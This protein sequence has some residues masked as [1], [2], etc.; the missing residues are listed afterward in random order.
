MNYSK[1]VAAIDDRI[2]ANGRREITGQTLHD[3]LEAMV[4]SLGAG[5]QV[6]GVLSPDDDPG[7]PD[8][9][10][11]FLAA[12]PGVYRNCGGLAVTELSW[13]IWG[14]GEWILKP[15]DVPFGVTVQEWIR[16]AVAEERSRALIAEALLQKNIDTEAATREAE[17][18]ALGGR[19]DKE[20]SD[21]EAAVA[22]EADARDKADKALQA[23][24]DAEATERKDA[25]AAEA[26]ARTDADAALGVRIDTETAER[27]QADADEKAAREAADATLQGNIDKEQERAEGAESALRSG[28][29]QEVSDRKEAVAAEASARDAAD[30][31]LGGRIDTETSERKAADA[32]EADTRDKAD[33]ALQAAIDAEEAART[34]ADTKEAEDRAAAVK[35]EADARTAADTALGT[36]IDTETTDRKA[37]DTALGGRIDTEI[38]DRKTADTA[39]D[40][41][42]TAIEG[43][44]PATASA[45]NKLADTEFVNSSIATA[46]ATFRGTFDTLETLKATEA[47][48]N[49]YAFYVHKDEAGNTCYDKYTYDGA[50]WKFEYRLNNSSFTAA[51]WAALNSGITA[52]VIAALQ[53]ADKTNAAAIAKEVQDR[54]AA[55]AAEETARQDAD[56]ALG[57]RIDTKQAALVSGTNIKTVNGNS[58][59][60]EGDIEIKAGSEPLIV[61]MTRRAS[62]ATFRDTDKTSAE[63]AAAFNAGQ[64]VLVYD[65]MNDNE[66]ALWRGLVV[67][68]NNGI[69]CGN[70]RGTVRYQMLAGTLCIRLEETSVLTASID[71]A[72]P[73]A[74]TDTN[75]PSTKLL[76]SYVEANA[77]ES[78]FTLTLTKGTDDEYTMDRTWDELAAAVDAKTPVLFTMSGGSYSG[79]TFTATVMQHNS[80]VNLIILQGYVNSLYLYVVMTLNSGTVTISVS[81]ISLVNIDT[82]IPTAPTNHNVPGTKAIKDYVD[83]LVAD[84]QAQIDELKFG[85]VLTFTV[86]EGGTINWKSST[87]DI[88]KTIQYSKNGD[89][90]TNITSTID[91]AT[92]DVVAGDILRFKG[93]NETYAES[94][95]DYTFFGGTAIFAASGN[96]M[97]LVDGDNF[98]TLKTVSD[99]AF[100]QLFAGCA[101]L[102]SAPE[103]PATT[104]ASY[105][106][107]NMFYGC[108]G[109]TSAPELPAT[110]LASTCYYNMFRVDFRA[111]ASGHHAGELLLLQHVLRLCE[112]CKGYLPCDRHICITVFDG[113]A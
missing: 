76:K 107:Y 36:R 69:I 65:T 102:T 71:T 15:M 100:A 18:T 10:F 40:T 27:K 82:S 60:G 105:C 56:T 17:D 75:V 2:K 13:L 68:I 111:G 109:L 34:A 4:R 70:Y 97:S 8:Q 20:I 95:G 103:L 74:P 112:A 86:Q 62:D 50:E 72:M 22:A 64:V 33:K 108:T 6:A 7:E 29:A 30:V 73:T 43:K 58:L 63:I 77:G 25:D 39:L 59:L 11:A 81:E 53:E 51:Q 92:I 89:A 57:E 31:A 80:S 16:D 106:Y 99:Y 98:D 91:G 88:A 90:W 54:E 45:S 5:Y 21:R 24:I 52:E 38:T 49:D 104:L 41:R 93:Y 85:N 61:T 84:L 110:T 67:A 96:I 101:G 28:L 113:L 78:A 32:S 37:A 19:I 35:A 14:G 3:V 26:K 42:V 94:R 87:A 9:R 12:E 48:K 23:A 79:D 1:L 46:T 55:V 66:G 44:I 47:D 83:G